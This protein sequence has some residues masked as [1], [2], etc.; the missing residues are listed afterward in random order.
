MY[1][2]ENCLKINLS[3][4]VEN[5]ARMWRQ[6]RSLDFRGSLVDECGD[7]IADEMDSRGL[8]CF[9]VSK[10]P[11][12]SDEAT[13]EEFR[14]C[15]VAALDRWL[16]ESTPSVR[17]TPFEAS[18]AAQPIPDVYRPSP[19][20]SESDRPGMPHVDPYYAFDESSFDPDPVRR[21]PKPN[22]MDMPSL[23]VRKELTFALR[24]LIVLAIVAF[25]LWL[26]NR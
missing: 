2:P 10:E 19:P 15:V 5:A 7:Y 21:P 4:L 14:K 16:V 6:T 11:L 1:V 13:A 24:A 3:T 20:F 25:I 18:P 26:M 12:F 17:P 9:L 23:T 8:R 22:Q